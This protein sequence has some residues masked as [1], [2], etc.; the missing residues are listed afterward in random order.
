M[1]TTALSNVRAEPSSRNRMIAAAKRLF[2]SAGYENTTTV[3]IAREA[4]TSESQLVKH[5]GSKEGLLE[6]IFEEGW[7]GLRMQMANAQ[8]IASPRERLKA[9][10][11]A[12][13]Q[14]FAADP[15]L[16]DLMLLEGRRIRREG[17]MIMLT[18]SYLEFVKVMDAL[19]ESAQK[20]LT[21]EYPPQL[22]RSSLMG[23]FEG[24]LRDRVLQE[25]YGHSAGYE[26]NQAEKFVAEVVDRLFV[27]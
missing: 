2:S 19:V 18:A 9:I 13:V 3:M 12:V 11:R 26:I 4:R 25:K 6:A 24:V 22:V 20:S 16:R 1:P 27:A 10:M 14:A 21:S 8:A 23:M 15:E 7:S 17:K 5:F